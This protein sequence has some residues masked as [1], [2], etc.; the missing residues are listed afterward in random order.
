M[1]NM[2]SR[3]A[4]HAPPKGG[5]LV[6]SPEILDTFSGVATFWEA[7]SEHLKSNFNMFITGVCK[8]FTI[9]KKYIWQCSWSIKL[10][11]IVQR[12]DL[13]G[14]SVWVHKGF[15][16]CLESF[17]IFSRVATF[18]EA[19][20]STSNLISMF[21]SPDFEISTRFGNKCFWKCL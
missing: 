20:Q 21:S 13:E 14:F 7:S 9:C 5:Q 10:L 6:Y 19:R 8:Y 12:L 18:C 1:N 16:R 3:G 11:L 17:D 2:N 4:P 15:K